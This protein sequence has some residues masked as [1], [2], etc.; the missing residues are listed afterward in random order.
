MGNSDSKAESDNL[1]KLGDIFW[2]SSGFGQ[3]CFLQVK[4]VDHIN[5]KPAYYICFQAGKGEVV[6]SKNELLQG[7]QRYGGVFQPRLT[8]PEQ[9]SWNQ[10]K[11]WRKDKDETLNLL[12]KT[13]GV[14]LRHAI[15]DRKFR[16]SFDVQLG[17]GQLFLDEIKQRLNTEVC[18]PLG[19][20]LTKL[21]PTGN[22]A[23]NFVLA[24]R[25]EE[26]K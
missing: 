19:L 15:A 17:Q 16:G 12:V 22:Y 13:F 23:V 2:W 14:L 5:N 8:E 18:W 6:L 11:D 10:L 3:D 26:K 7:S 21:E 4:Q 24:E 1:P 25:M 20:E 9:K